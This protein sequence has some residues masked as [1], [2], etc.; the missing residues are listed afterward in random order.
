MSMF[1]R[2]LHI[3]PGNGP[4]RSGALHVA[5]LCV[6]GL[7][8]DDQELHEFLVGLLD[9]ARAQQN[10]LRSM[11]LTYRDLGEFR[12]IASFLVPWIDTGHKH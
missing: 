8:R 3:L 6:E 9:K 7:K 10:E 1:N 2:L 12:E 4:A 5:R 11:N